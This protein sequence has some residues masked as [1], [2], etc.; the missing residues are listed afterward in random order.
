MRPARRL[1][2]RSMFGRYRDKTRPQAQEQPVFEQKQFGGALNED[3]PPVGIDANELAALEN[4]IAFENRLEGRSGS[5]RFSATALPGSDTIYRWKQHATSKRHLL[6]RT[7]GVYISNNAAMG[8]W[9]EMTLPRRTTASPTIAGD[10]ASQL[11]TLGV[12]G[13]ASSNT[14]GG[15]G[16]WTL[17]NSGTT[18]TFSIY[19][20]SAGSTLVARGTRSGDGVLHFEGQNN[21]GMGGSVTVTY[22]TDD[23]D[24]ANNI[25]TIY[26]GSTLP[27]L[28]DL[29]SA[30]IVDYKNDFLI[31]PG[32]TG[33]AIIYCDTTTLTC[34]Q[35]GDNSN[36]GEGY[37]AS[38]ITNS[39]SKLSSTPYGRRYL[40]CFSRIVDSSG[41]PSV[42]LNRINGTLQFEGPPFYN[43][44][45]TAADYGEYWSATANT[46]TLSYSMIGQT[47]RHPM[48]DAAVHYTHCSIYATLDIGDNGI[49][50]DGV[51]NNREIYA[52]LADVDISQVSYSDAI[53]DDVL[54]S[55]IAAGTLLNTRFWK[56]YSDAG[57]TSIGVVSGSFL[58]HAA[59]HADSLSKNI[60]NYTQLNNPRHIGFHNPTFQYFNTND[61]IQRFM[62]VGNNVVVLCRSKTYLVAPYAYEN[63]G[64]VESVF[65]LKGFN[66][67]SETIGVVDTGTVAAIDSAS[68]IARCS[69]NSIRIFSGGTWM[70]QNLADQK[71]M[72]ITRSML[73][74]SVGGFFGR[75]YYLWYRNSSSDTYNTKCLRFGFGRE[76]GSGWCRVTG[77][78]WIYPPTDFGAEVIS[79]DNNIQR[80][81]VLDSPDT[82]WYWVETFAGPSGYSLSKIYKDKANTSGVGGSSIATKFRT[83]EII[84]REESHTVY[85][86]E[87]HIYVRPTG[88][89]FVAGMSLIS[90]AYA[91]GDPNAKA[92]V[93][94]A[95]LSGGDIQYF[96]RISGKR[97]QQEYEFSESGVTVIATDTHYQSHD[98]KSV[99]NGPYETPETGH[100]TALSTNM[101]HWLTR[102][103]NIMNRVTG[104]S[105]TLSNTAP[106]NVTG[107]DG[108]DYALQ[109]YDSGV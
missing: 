98:V 4:F 51:G 8:S 91:D 100:Q 63:S 95:S 70:D 80:L 41:N 43:T 17:T 66:P 2:G 108:K 10:T 26:S 62:V 32:V 52:W 58:F 107:P 101:T 13:H 61:G 89:T 103:K 84:G 39:G 14:N 102:P 90:R 53:T 42:T 5:Q 60:V 78:A 59:I 81:L 105:Y 21:S 88:A 35:I 72:G 18:R 96:E 77:A 65:V 71:V 87:S 55:R 24:T 106:Q 82:T 50:T 6:V 83:R 99:G 25:L 93:S 76:S 11:T 64:N 68:F 19:S 75:A 27:S 44:S 3:S 57:K 46:F 54:R 97:I 33:Y 85:H 38:K 86:E 15:L 12:A 29:V 48:L 94:G 7:S 28:G 37:P 40:I 16:Y 45:A 109:F 79:D 67:V 30:Q 31:F 34:Y 22:T 73:T 69:D 23:T 9:T 47:N 56:E 104:T 92:T 36:N 74:G 20:D 1:A 49:G